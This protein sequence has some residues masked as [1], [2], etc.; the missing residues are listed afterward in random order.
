MKETEFTSQINDIEYVA[1][2]IPKSTKYLA[3]FDKVLSYN[4]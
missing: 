3:G 4:I 1:S 2:N